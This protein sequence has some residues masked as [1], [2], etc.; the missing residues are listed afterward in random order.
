MAGTNPLCR[1]P[2][3]S[4]ILTANK[5]ARASPFGG[6]GGI[7]DYAGI[8]TLAVL[9]AHRD[10]VD[11]FTRGDVDISTHSQSLDGGL[12]RAADVHCK[13]GQERT[14]VGTRLV[15]AQARGCFSRETW[16]LH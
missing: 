9:S 8:A 3:F 4:P 6:I 13:W 11:S 10:A 16:H 5:I 12:Y 14:I 15:L 7:R 1:R 2:P